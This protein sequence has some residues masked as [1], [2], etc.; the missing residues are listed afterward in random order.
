MKKTSL[1]TIGLLTS[2]S[3][4]VAG[5]KS[6]ASPSTNA[7][8]QAAP[9]APKTATD[10][11]PSKWKEQAPA[12]YNAKFTTSQGAF[13][14]K[15]TRDWAPL[16]ADRFYNLV[17]SGYYNDIRFFRVL[18]KPSPFMAQF[19]IHGDPAVS[20]AWRDARI[21]DDPVK[22]SNKRGFVT[23]AMGGPATRTTQV[24]INYADNANLDRGG[25]APFG[26][27]TEGMSVVDSLYADYGEGGGAPDQ[28]AMQMKGNEYL[29]ASFPKLD[30]IKTATIQP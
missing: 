28:G 14:I 1:L 27:V 22:Q 8:A 9:A 24:F 13:T 12:T 29:K 19:G 21:A 26:E 20:A 23:Y 4:S 10:L 18:R 30:Y 17:K 7:A 6:D 3:I 11:A 25:F 16:G 5:C 15:V 2:L